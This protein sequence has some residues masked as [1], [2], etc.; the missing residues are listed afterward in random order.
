MV[1]QA[2]AVFKM[3]VITV[4]FM[5]MF[6]RRGTWLAEINLPVNGKLLRHS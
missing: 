5:V 4:D 3:I 6:K 1:L 2:K